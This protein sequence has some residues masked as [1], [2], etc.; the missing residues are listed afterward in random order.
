VTVQ[1]IADFTA[2]ATDVATNQV[3]TFTNTSTGTPPLSYVWDFGDSTATVT[4]TNPTHAY[5]AAGS[6]TVT[7]TVTNTDGSDSKQLPITVGAPAAAS[8]N[9]SATSVTT[10]QVVTFTNTSTGTALTFVWSFGDGMTSTLSSPTHA[11]AV[12]GLYTVTLTAHNNYGPDSAAQA[13]I[14]VGAPAAASFNAS[15]TN[16]GINQVVTFTNTSTGTALTFLWNFGDGVTS[17]VTSP[18]HAYTNAGVYTVTLTAHNVYGPDSNAQTAITVVAADLWV[19]KTGP[20]TARVGDIV[21]YTITFGNNTASAA[22][23]AWITDTVLAG[24][25]PITQFVI[26]LGTVPPAPFSSTLVY[27]LPVLPIYAGITFTNQVNINTTDADGDPAND[28]AMTQTFVGIPPFAAFAPSAMTAKVNTAI[29]FTNAS[30]GTPPLTYLWDLGDGSAVATTMNVTHVY[31]RTGVFTVTLT[32]SNLWGPDSTY[33]VAV[34]IVP[35]T[36][37]LPIITTN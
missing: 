8:F 26:P 17:T 15:A 33:S 14:T 9:A 24:T 25:N 10:N 32:A 18:T 16:V 21:T 34:T 11:Y 2:S 31:T 23:N 1:P 13:A 3:I 28:A 36:T 20:A 29:D 35:Y 27:T 22:N 6:Y 37:F 4:D 19:Q 30:V 12:A 7:L 5:T